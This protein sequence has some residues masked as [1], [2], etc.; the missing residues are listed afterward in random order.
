MA[1][2]A[3]NIEVPFDMLFPLLVY[4]M[5]QVQDT[6]LGGEYGDELNWGKI[7]EALDCQRKL[8]VSYEQLESLIYSYK[9]GVLDKR[10]PFRWLMHYY[11]ANY[12]DVMKS[13]R[14]LYPDLFKE[15]A[16][17]EIVLIGVETTSPNQEAQ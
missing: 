15:E 6:E 4:Y 1:R 7:V 9:M 3:A 14:H 5:A 13:F 2:P 12:S 11:A 10:Q 17:G 8:S 16:D